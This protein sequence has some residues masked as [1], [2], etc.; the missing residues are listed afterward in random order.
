MALALVSVVETNPIGVAKYKP[1]ICFKGHLKQTYISN[2]ME[3]FSFKGHSGVHG[4]IHIKEF[5]SRADVG[6]R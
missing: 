5:K 6:Y 2:K 3:H 1:L 4:C